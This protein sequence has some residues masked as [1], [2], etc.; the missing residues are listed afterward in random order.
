MFLIDP[1][2]EPRQAVGQQLPTTT[3]AG[4]SGVED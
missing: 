1:E 4:A 3:T 2:M